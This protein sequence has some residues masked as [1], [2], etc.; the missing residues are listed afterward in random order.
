MGRH[1]KGEKCLAAE[2]SPAFTRRVTVLRLPFQIVEH[3]QFQKFIRLSRS[4][5]TLPKFPTGRTI[6]R[7]LRRTIKEKQQRLL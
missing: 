7:L 6:Q 3:P 2:Y 1:W 5:L 4:M